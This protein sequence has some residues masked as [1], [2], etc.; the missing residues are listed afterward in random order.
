MIRLKLLWRIMK[1]QKKIIL[2]LLLCF[3]IFLQ[4]THSYS[5]ETKN[6]NPAN[7]QHQYSYYLTVCTIFNN[8]APW[9]KEWLEYHK[10]IGVEHFFMYNN[11][12]TDN[13]L[14]VLAPYIE[15]GEVTLIDWPNGPN[16]GEIWSWVN[17]TQIPAFMD[18]IK[19]TKSTSWWVAFI[20]T[21]E[22]IVPRKDNSLVS[23]LKKYDSSANLGGLAVNWSCYGSSGLWDVPQGKLMIES[24]TRKDDGTHVWAKVVKSIVHPEYVTGATSPHFFKY[25]RGKYGVYSNKKLFKQNRPGYIE[26][27]KINHYYMRTLNYFYNEKLEKKIQMDNKP[28]SDYELKIYFEIGDKKEDQEKDIFRFVPALR[29]IMKLVHCKV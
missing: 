27:I 4:S 8:E 22:F 18:C 6:Y 7:S 16:T 1:Y 10:L 23:F 11:E 2:H 3:Y 5:T 24:L 12:S 20:D 29:T 25:K 17:N 26:D 28:L 13:Y 19:S 15:N 9:L 14:E 21:D